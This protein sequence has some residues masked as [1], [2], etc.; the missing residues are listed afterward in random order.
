[1]TSHCRRRRLFRLRPGP[2]S[3]RRGGSRGDLGGQRIGGRRGG[4][5]REGRPN[6]HLLGGNL[7]RKWRLMRFI[8]GACD[9]E[10]SPGEQETC[11]RHSQEPPTFRES[12]GHTSDGTAGRSPVRAAALPKGRRVEVGGLQRLDALSFRP[13]DQVLVGKTE[14]RG[15]AGRGAVRIDSTTFDSPHVDITSEPPISRRSSCALLVG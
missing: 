9:R 2:M 3:S 14:G 5:A 6:R 1:V 15:R 10:P 13:P 12:R 4:W 7:G 11:A 8:R